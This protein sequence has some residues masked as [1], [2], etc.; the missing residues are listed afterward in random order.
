VAEVDPEKVETLA[1]RCRTLW[2]EQNR[3]DRS[4]AVERVCALYLQ[5]AHEQSEIDAV[6]HD[7]LGG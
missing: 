2:M 6:L 4:E 1:Q 7:R 3:I 5:P